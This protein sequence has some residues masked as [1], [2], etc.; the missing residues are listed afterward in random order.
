MIV[1][2]IGAINIRGCLACDL[3]IVLGLVSL[4]AFGFNLSNCLN[5]LSD[6]HFNMISSVNEDLNTL[7]LVAKSVGF[8][9]DFEA[10]RLAEE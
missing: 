4:F 7:L 3:E 8:L 2:A 1:V 10:G 6:S 9:M 5:R